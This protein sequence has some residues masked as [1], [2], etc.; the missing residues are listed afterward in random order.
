VLTPVLPVY[1]VGGS[2]TRLA[3]TVEALSLDHDVTVVVL[4]GFAA[5]NHVETLRCRAR[6]LC[7]GVGA[8]LI[9]A[10]DPGT[11]RWRQ[12]LHTPT[13]GAGRPWEARLLAPRHGVAAAV[14]GADLVWV[15]KLSPFL[16]AAI[17]PHPNLVVDLDDLEER[18]S[19]PTTIRQRARTLALVRHRRRVIERARL[20][21]VCSDIDRGHLGASARVALLPNTSPAPAHTIEDGPSRTDV[22]MV[23]RMAYPPNAEGARWFVEQVWPSIHAANP[24]ARCRIAGQLA[25]ELPLD[26]LAS[27]DGVD[28][29]GHVDDLSAGLGRAAVCVAPILV[30]SGTRVKIIEAFAWGVP[31]VATTVGAEG[32]DAH[33]GEH[34][35]LA[36]DAESFASAVVE[37]LDDDGLRASLAAAARQLYQERYSTERFTARV[38]Q[39]A[40]GGA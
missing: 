8:E 13:G 35:L 3:A 7:D 33:H 39:I 14:A 10:D 26:D 11:S 28:L 31:V 17:P 32:L 25:P 4:D 19:P 24:D 2:F 18:V 40:A 27:I 22:L 15:F 34:L 38:H 20:A 16:M 21:L 30:G 12:W 1:G 5:G 9:V 23:G 37:L 29:L 6:R 36:D